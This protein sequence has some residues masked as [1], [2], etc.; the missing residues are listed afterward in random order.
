[1]YCSLLVY[2]TVVRTVRLAKFDMYA[3]C[4]LHHAVT[5][6]TAASCIK[7]NERSILFSVLGV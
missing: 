3:R 5:N 7:A 2:C 1:M 6:E 4:V